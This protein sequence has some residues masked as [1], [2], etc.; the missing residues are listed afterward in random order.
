MGEK[1]GLEIVIEAARLLADDRNIR[2]VLCGDG[3][4]KTRLQEMATGFSNIKWLPLQPLE[5]L[6][7][8]LNLANVHLLPQSSSAADLVMPSKLTGMLA[9]GR[10][11]LATAEQDTEL[12][13]VLVGRGLVVSPGNKQDFANAIRMLS[14]NEGLCAILGNA[15]RKYAEENLESDAVLATFENALVELKKKR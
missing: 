6:N 3:A 2:F 4:A 12:D 9:S 14:V 8:L 7:E 15:G 10:P 11:V 1:Q 13:N 5:K